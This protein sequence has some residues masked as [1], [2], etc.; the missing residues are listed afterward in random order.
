MNRTDIDADF[1]KF[2]DIAST[3]I[4]QSDVPQ[5]IQLI[6]Y[7]LYK[8]ATLNSVDFKND[9]T[10]AYSNLINAFKI[11]AWMQ[12]KHLT[13]EQAKIAYIEQVKKLL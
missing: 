5:D 8:Q 11:N 7:G 2:F 12:V 6:L 9:P 1:E 3:T 13:Q 10:N 4:K